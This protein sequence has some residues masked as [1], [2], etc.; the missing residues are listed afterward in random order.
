MKAQ[1]QG[2]RRRCQFIAVQPSAHGLAIGQPPDTPGFRQD[3]LATHI[4]D[5]VSALGRETNQ[6]LHGIGAIDESC[7]LD[8]Q[9]RGRSTLD[10]PEPTERRD[11]Q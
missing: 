7:R 9:I 1:L 5:P 10:G 3:A 4:H 2:D 8:R 6:A 11:Q